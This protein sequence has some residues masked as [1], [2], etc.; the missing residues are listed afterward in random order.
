MTIHPRVPAGPAPTLAL[1]LLVLALGGLAWESRILLRGRDEAEALR[2]RAAELTKRIDGQRTE[3]DRL[4]T[5]IQ[6]WEAGAPTKESGEKSPEAQVNLWADQLVRLRKFFADHPDQAI[7]ELDLLSELD[8]LRLA[9]AAQFEEPDGSRKAYA[10]LRNAARAQF[11]TLL[12]AA[13]TK[14]RAAHD[15]V[16][17]TSTSELAPYLKPGVDPAILNRYR[18]ILSGK[19]DDYSTDFFTAEF[20]TT[21]TGQA[22][23]ERYDSRYY[24]G[25]SV[26]AVQ[27]WLGGEL[28]DS[29]QEAR[30]AFAKANEGKKHVAGPTEN[31][32]E[33]LPYITSPVHR[34]Y[35]A[36]TA[37]YTGSHGGKSP[38]KAEDLLPYLSSPESRSFAERLFLR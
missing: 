10:S 11:S 28:Q 18:M 37:A 14:Y 34:D 21:E 26:S 12:S 5:Q 2:Q 33:L 24:I 27:T 7:P 17:P 15:S 1:T 4:K 29:K 32:T 20:F 9:R 23:D 35:L 22:I 3:I 36:A 31:L 25:P 16:L 8:W 6:V 30:I 19:T 38:A 13:I